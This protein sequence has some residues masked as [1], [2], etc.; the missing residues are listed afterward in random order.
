MV[1]RGWSISASCSRPMVG[2]PIECRLPFVR[3]FLSMII[4][5]FWSKGR[6]YPVRDLSLLESF[7]VRFLPMHISAHPYSTIGPSSYTS[8]V[9]VE[10]PYLSMQSPAHVWISARSVSGDTEANT[11][12]RLIASNSALHKLSV[13]GEGLAHL[14]RLTDGSH[15][16]VRRGGP[17]SAK[18]RE[19]LLH[20]YAYVD[21]AV[22]PKNTKIPRPHRIQNSALC[23][24]SKTGATIHTTF[25][26]GPRAALVLLCGV[27]LVFRWHGILRRQG[28][29][30]G[31]E[32]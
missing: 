27:Y 15:I 24:R 32:A 26:K 7:T 14:L 30:R 1:Q 16:L 5:R 28:R 2:S 13:C 6:S 25:R 23:A 29:T 11:L 10:S 9:P 17:S 18:F 20:I 31:S 12:F 3:S 8:F 4:C 19:S 22:G 21:T